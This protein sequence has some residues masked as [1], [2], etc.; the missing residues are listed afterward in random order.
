M[1]LERVIHFGVILGDQVNCR[2]PKKLKSL[3]EVP[4]VAYLNVQVLSFKI[5]LIFS[6]Q[7]VP[8]LGYPFRKKFGRLLKRSSTENAKIVDR[9]SLCSV[10]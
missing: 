6:P 9:S 8:R 1:F 10:T 2:S 7:R 5:N 3:I 4:Y